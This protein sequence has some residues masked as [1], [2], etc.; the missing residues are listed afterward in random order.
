MV[1]FDRVPTMKPTLALGLSGLEVIHLSDSI[2]NDDIAKGLPE[3]EAYVPLARQALL[4][5]GSAYMELVIPEG[6]SDGIVQIHVTEEQAWLFRSKTR[7]GDL[8]IDGKTNIGIPLLRKLYA[9]LSSF[10]SGIEIETSLVSEPPISEIGKM[11]LAALKEGIDARRTP[12]DNPDT[13]T[14]AIC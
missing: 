4:L 12:S 11:Y 3:R 1:L 13:D 10:N 8:A 9:L 2:A 14:D 5:L 7:T 6:V